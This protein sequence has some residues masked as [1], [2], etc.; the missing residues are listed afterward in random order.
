MKVTLLTLTL[1]VTC[2][3]LIITGH[4]DAASWAALAAIFIVMVGGLES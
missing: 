1:I 2:V 3:A 4:R